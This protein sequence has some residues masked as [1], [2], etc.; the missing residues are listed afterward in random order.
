MDTEKVDAI[1]R[2]SHPTKVR[3]HQIL[4]G[5]AGFYRKYVH[6]YANIVVLMMDQLKTQGK[7]VFWG[8]A[9]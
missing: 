4:L 5:M 2:W 9:K 8:D 3:E 6:D 1:L 7:T